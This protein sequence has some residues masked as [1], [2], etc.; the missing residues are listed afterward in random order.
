MVC[1]RGHSKVLLA[2]G[3]EIVVANPCRAID[4]LD[5]PLFQFVEFLSQF[6][7]VLGAHG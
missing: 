5:V 7:E 3:C 6:G 1:L 4:F 2:N